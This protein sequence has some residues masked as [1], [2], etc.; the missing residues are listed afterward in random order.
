MQVN[1]VITQVDGQDVAGADL[2]D[3][4]SMILGELGTFATLRF[5]REV[6]GEMMEYSV[7]LMR[8]NAAYFAELKR[9]NEMQV[10]TTT[11]NPCLIA[12]AL[13]GSNGQCFGLNFVSAHWIIER[14][15]V[16]ACRSSSTTEHTL[17][18]N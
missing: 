13:L 15:H 7:S 3:L 4:R 2:P 10:C 16:F 14:L 11:W 9:K 6:D 17:L 1:D 12:A 5:E 18:R 8:G